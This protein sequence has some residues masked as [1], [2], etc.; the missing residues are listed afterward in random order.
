MYECSINWEMLE[1]G[2][3]VTH[4]SHMLIKHISSKPP[5]P[6]IPNALDTQELIVTSFTQGTCW[7]RKH[8]VY[9]IMVSARCYHYYW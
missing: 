9:D 7:L 4:I 2:G 8:P 5:G 3:T 6:F 1:P